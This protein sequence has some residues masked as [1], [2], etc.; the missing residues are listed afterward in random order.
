MSGFWEFCLDFWGEYTLKFYNS[1]Y[2]HIELT[3]KNRNALAAGTML[4][5]YRIDEVIGQG[6]FGI[7]YLAFDTDLQRKVAIKECYPR[8][9]VQREGTRVVT[10]SPDM[11]AD[12]DWALGKFVDEATTL[13][14]FKH[15]GIVQVL[16]IIK[17]ENESAYMVLE[18]VEGQAFGAWLKQHKGTMS[19][20]RLK[21]V[22]TPIFN[23]LEIVHH[24]D[25]VHRDI[26]PDNIFIRPNGEAVLLDFGTA[27]QSIAL[28]TRTMNLVVKDGYSAPEQ[29]YAETKRQGPWTD[30]YAL[31]AM[32]YEAVAGKRPL[33]SVERQDAVLNDEDDPLP[34]LASL[35]HEG[36]GYSRAFL[37]AIM[38]GLQPKASQRPQSLEEWRK[39]LLPDD[40]AADLAAS[41]YD[42]QEDVRTQ[43]LS[44]QAAAAISG[45]EEGLASKA[46]APSP[47][48]KGFAIVTASVVGAALLVGGAF[49]ALQGQNNT[50]PEQQISKRL[51]EPD[52]KDPTQEALQAQQA[53]LQRRE[54]KDWQEAR[55]DDTLGGYQSFLRS[56]P[57]TAHMLELQQALAKLSD[58]WAK[59]ISS[60]KLEHARA[61]AANEDVIAIAGEAFDVSLGRQGLI[62]LISHSGKEKWRAEFGKSGYDSFRDILITESGD[63]VAVGFSRPDGSARSSAM[64]VGYSPLGQI[65]WSLDMG[66]GTHNELKS[67]AQLPGGDLIASGSIYAGARQR[68]DG[69]LVRLDTAGRVLFDKSFGGPGNDEF[70]D[71]QVLP[72]GDLAVVGSNQ[73]P[74]RNDEEFWT[75]K[76]SADGKLLWENSAGGSK[77]DY[78]QSA[79]VRPDGQ[80]YAV[81]DTNSL[82]SGSVDGMV[83]R[84][85]RDNRMHPKSIIAKSDDYLTA[86]SATPQGKVLVAGYTASKATGHSDGWVSQYDA[87][88]KTVEWERVIGDAKSEQIEAI[89]VLADGTIVAVGAKLVPGQGSAGFWVVKLGQDGHYTARSHH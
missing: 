27:K 3:M 59:T 10:T 13:A 58:P 50:E 45:Q 24:K 52:K 12:F 74:G 69:W 8:D 49:W 83:M 17:D 46:A 19:E 42:G 55:L 53:E 1:C 65:K 64:I 41:E 75:L 56:Y 51:P 81:G 70:N 22:I 62:H 78:L 84:I 47:R 34:H 61:V 20:A 7:T 25:I 28:H 88:L 9:F 33:T 44:A 63:I 79:S 15:S 60:G 26:A 18:F 85:S 73:K 68:K 37:D 89:D 40:G 87:D 6:G 35:G 71:L 67:I 48:G 76:L 77:S 38:L 30:I 16:Q 66:S 39:I 82:G 80:F 21:H 43:V 72:T 86:I 4:Q 11:V 32:L 2:N 5:Q 29:Y 14:R 31:A 23:A 57:Q 36:E 54:T